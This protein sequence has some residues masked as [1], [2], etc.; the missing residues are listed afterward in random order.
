MRNEAFRPEECRFMLRALRLAERGRGRVEPNPMVGAVFVKDGR[1]V[2]EGYHRRF[3]EA[4]AEVNGIHAARGS[5]AGATVYVTLE[6]CNHFGKTPPC[7]QTLIDAKV[8]RVVAAIADPDPRVCGR[9]FVRLRRAG[10]RVDVGLCADEAT[11][12]AA[13]YLT[14]AHLRR[15]YVILKWAQSI[16]G[17][18]ATSRGESRWIS[19]EASRRRVHRLRAV[20]DGILVGIG[21]VLRDDPQLTARHVPVRRV[22]TRVVLDTHLRIPPNAQVTR[23]AA[24]VPTLVLTSAAALAARAA[25][26][27]ELQRCGVE[28]QACRVRQGHIDLADALRRLAQRGMTNVL[29][30]AGSRV[31]TGMLDAGLADEA[32][33]FVAPKLIGGAD[34]PRAWAGRG[35][36]DLAE[37]ESV[38]IVSVRRLG[39]DLCWRLRLTRAPRPGNV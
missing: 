38:R 28:I 13:P 2:A 39:D 34:A 12:L 30:E 15:P 29:V 16:D 26:A 19:G 11:E 36:H 31:L 1:I 7:T 37:A 20:C 24:Q 21:T 9:G 8:A 5:L 23:T 14:R 33:V 22:A 4:H 17:K 27:R 18:L 10:I 6:P 25:R 35:V 32:L 3:G